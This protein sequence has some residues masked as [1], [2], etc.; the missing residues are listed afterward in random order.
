MIEQNRLCKT[1]KM[2][3]FLQWKQILQIWTD[4]KQKD[5]KPGFLPA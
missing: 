5:V 1:A 3:F 2:I 4:R